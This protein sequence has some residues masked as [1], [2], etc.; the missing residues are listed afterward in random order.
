LPRFAGQGL[1][2]GRPAV[3]FLITALVA[4]AAVPIGGASLG[5]RAIT[6][7]SS[8]WATPSNQP[9][10]DV[11]ASDAQR[12]AGDYYAGTVVNDDSN[13]VN[14]YLANAPQS[15][16]DQLET[17]HPGLYV[18]DNHSPNSRSALLALSKSLDVAA[19]K[20]H[21]IDVVEWGPT[22]QGYLRVGVSSDIETAQARIDSIYG[23]GRIQVYLVEALHLTPAAGKP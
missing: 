17:T 11:A 7:I 12:I 13:W 4:L 3:A 5:G 10:L 9:D 19:L 23:S 1:Q 18:I 14:V 2:L 22:P 16:I 8:L 21:G 6:G 15:V 20:T